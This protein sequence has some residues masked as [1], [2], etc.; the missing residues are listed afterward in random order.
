MEHYKLL[1]QSLLFYTKNNKSQKY[2]SLPNTNQLQL[3]RKKSIVLPPNLVLSQRN[4]LVF[5]VRLFLP[6]HSNTLK[7]MKIFFVVVGGAFPLSWYNKLVTYITVV[8]TKH[9][10]CYMYIEGPIV[11]H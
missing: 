9:H 8:I 10:L 3:E 4:F 7:Y 6:L 5:L 2:T 1:T 11:H